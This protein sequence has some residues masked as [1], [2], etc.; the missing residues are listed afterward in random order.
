[1][2]VKDLIAPVSARVGGLVGG[3]ITLLTALALPWR[4]DKK[5]LEYLAIMVVFALDKYLS[6]AAAVALDDGEE[7]EE[8]YV[9][10]TT[11]APDFKPEEL[12]VEWT[13]LPPGLV[14]RIFDLT[15]RT[16]DAVAA[17]DVTAEH[18]DPPDY[19]QYFEERQLQF[20]ELALVAAQLAAELRQLAKLPK[21]TKN[22][23]WDAVA[24][25]NAKRTKLLDQQ[26][27]RERRNRRDEIELLSEEQSS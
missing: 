12:K 17:I 13:T 7:D 21:R 6:E 11:T 26:A 27:A 24:E 15:P 19:E 8:G 1:M 16:A 9:H 5:S 23:H 25:V 20:A 3:G 4:K 2:D 10:K 14:Y 18:A 22:P